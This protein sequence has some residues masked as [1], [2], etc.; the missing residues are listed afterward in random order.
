MKNQIIK[1]AAALLSLLT[2]SSCAASSGASETTAQ[3]SS[4]GAV[5][6]AITEIPETE[7]T[8]GLDDRDMDGFSLMILHHSS[9]FMT[10]CV[11]QLDGELNGE[12]LNDAI[13]ERNASVKE[14]FNCELLISEQDQVGA[15]DVSKL[16]LSGDTTYDIIMERDYEISKSAQYLLDWSK[17]PYIS[18]DEDWWYPDAS[19][20][21]LFGDKQVAAANSISLSCV[22]RA[23]GFAF[24]K[25]VYESLMLDRDI[26]DYVYAG[27]WTV[28]NMAMMC[29]GAASDINGDGVMDE[30][31]R[32]GIGQSS[33][34]EVFARLINGSNVFFISRDESGYPEFT[35]DT[36]EAGVN[37]LLKIYELFSDD[38]VYSNKATN[39][40][41]ATAYGDILKG[42]ALFRLCHARAMGTTLR[43]S[44]YD[45]GFVPNP[46]YDETQ[47]RYY[48]TT[49]AF[50]IMTLPLTLPEER[51]ENVGMILEAL[52]FASQHSVLESYKEDIV[53]TKYSQDSDTMAMFDLAF[54]S[55]VFDLGLVLWEADIA[56]P[57]IKDI[58]ASGDGNVVSALASRKSKID[59][60]LTDF[61]DSLSAV[62]E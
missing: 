14:R 60:K 54:N 43:D 20:S 26:Y 36:D 55:M 50:E 53:I 33:Y 25:D 19:N 40:D 38:G 31:D 46:K 27:D 11:T 56:N 59:G 47:D 8:D 49:W 24:N 28:E 42:T 37:K 45:I 39:M 34:K 22:S 3:S 41:D 44:A 12:L 23:S 51:Y 6:D 35:L 32:Y 4:G 57:L 2:L 13:Y 29:R 58:Y 16:V 5:A 52:A 48:S 18:L 30:N 21:F 61:I 15:T 9:N 17:L 7:E 62:G 1:A 10:W